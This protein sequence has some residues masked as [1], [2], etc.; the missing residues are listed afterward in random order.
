MTVKELIEKLSLA[1][2]QDVYV[3]LLHDDLVYS[4]NDVLVGD[5]QVLLDS[6]Y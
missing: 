2:N 6:S 3:C 5:K 1:K 4:I